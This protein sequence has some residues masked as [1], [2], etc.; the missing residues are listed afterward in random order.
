MPDI[1]IVSILKWVA[2]NMH[3][4][5]QDPNE[6]ISE[7]TRILEVNLV[8]NIAILNFIAPPDSLQTAF[9][10][11]QDMENK[12]VHMHDIV[13]KAQAVAKDNMLVR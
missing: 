13:S 4:T 1:T 7:L 3:I 12:L 5:L 9:L 6:T 10:R 11:E 8:Y 2:V